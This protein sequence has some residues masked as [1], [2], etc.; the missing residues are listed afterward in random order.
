MAVSEMIL[1]KIRGIVGPGGW[2][3]PGPGMA[4]F[5]REERALWQ[6]NTPLVVRP[7]STQETAQVIALCA[8]AGVAVVPQGGNTGLVGGSVARGEIILSLGR[9]NRVRALD[10]VNHTLTAEA[11]C[12]LADLQATAD[13]HDC[14]FPLSLAAEG[15]CQIGGNISTNAGGVQVLRYGNTRDL[16]LGLEVVLPDGRIW[17]GLRGLRKDNT[18]YDLKQLFIGAEG[19]LG[20]VTAA[21]LK[22]FP[23]PRDR[24]TAIAATS[25]LRN[26]LDIYQRVRHACGDS[27]SACELIDRT[28]LEFVLRHIPGTREPCGEAH[29]FYVLIE[30]TDPRADAGL[31]QGLEAV[32]E[33]ALK[34]G[35]VDDA[36]IAASGAQSADF[37]RIRETIPEAQKFEGGSIKHDVALPISKVAEFIEIAIERLAGAVAGIRPVVFGHLGDGN[38]HFNLSQ[39]IGADAAAFTARRPEINRIVYDL[40]SEMKGSFSAEHGIGLLK[41]DELNRYKSTVETD[42]MRTLKRAIDPKNILNPGKIV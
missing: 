38:I 39:P 2:V 19:T 31:R 23:K 36:A 35:V 4:P 22:L 33:Q 26:A 42:L 10:T 41:R 29:R 15:S 40:T 32:L 25:S 28:S 8:E 1:E 14:L 12:I 6:S 27:L 3:G 9:M 34:D 21:V 13:E 30:L 17:S 5:L 16:I 24:V 20:I 11:G 7:A 37:W 18:G